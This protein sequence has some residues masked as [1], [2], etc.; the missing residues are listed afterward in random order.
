MDKAGPTSDKRRAKRKAAAK[1]VLAAD[2]RRMVIAEFGGTM[3]AAEVERIS[4]TQHTVT[5][6]T[7]RAGKSGR[8]RAV[9]AGETDVPIGRF[10]HRARGGRFVGET[11]SEFSGVVAALEAIETTLRVKHHPQLLSRAPIPMDIHGTLDTAASAGTHVADDKNPGKTRS[12]RLSV[13]GHEASMRDCRLRKFDW[14]LV[15][16]V[17]DDCVHITSLDLSRNELWELPGLEMLL[18]LHHLDISRN[19]FRQLPP[20]LHALHQLR[21]LD[22]SHNML[23]GSSDA[24][25]VSIGCGSVVRRSRRTASV[26]LAALIT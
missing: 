21:T 9:Q 12:V 13:D 25:K 5:V 4:K 3:T 23:R 24:L 26:T 8:A 20:E 17:A 10:S 11:P 18:N 19:W 22:A 6:P 14:Q 7:S 15:C 2:V 16:P 1:S